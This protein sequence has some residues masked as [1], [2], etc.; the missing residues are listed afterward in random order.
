MSTAYL[1]IQVMYIQNDSQGLIH[2]LGAWEKVFNDSIS[3]NCESQPITHNYFLKFYM[4]QLNFWAVI[5]WNSSKI[6]R[7]MAICKWMSKQEFEVQ[8]LSDLL[9]N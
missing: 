7:D 6:D 9:I 8:V 2:V 3:Q 5:C 4:I 1:K